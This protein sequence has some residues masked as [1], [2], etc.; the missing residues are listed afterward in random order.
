[1]YHRHIVNRGNQEP[2]VELRVNLSKTIEE[3]YDRKRRGD[4][5][6]GVLVLTWEDDELQFKATQASISRCILLPKLIPHH[7]GG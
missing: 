6:V 2:Q 7:L 1:M 3:N 4:L 5:R